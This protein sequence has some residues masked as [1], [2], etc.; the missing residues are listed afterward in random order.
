MLQKHENYP[1]KELNT[2]HFDV[3]AKELIVTDSVN[4]I[5]EWIIQEKPSAENI[6]VLGG[7]SN[8]LFASDYT[9]TLI[10]P[11]FDQ[12][13][14]IYEDNDTVL[15]ETGA[16]KKWDDFVEFCVNNSYYGVENLSLIPGTVGAA[17]VQNIGAYGCE[18][19]DVIEKVNGI[20]LDS[21][22]LL[23][24]Y[25]SE[26][27]FG[28]RNS[29][30]KNELKNRTLVTSVVFRLSKKETYNLSYGRL[31]EKTKELGKINLQNIRKAVIDI[32]GSKLPDP[33]ITGNA[34]SFF[35][36]PEIST[37]LFD[38]LREDYPDIPGYPLDKGKMKIPAGWLIDKAGWKGKAMG[39]AAVHNDQALVLINRGDA[40]GTDI[41]KLASAIEK[42]IKNKFGIGLEKEVIVIR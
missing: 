7:G 34:G 17:P 21:A 12:I 32:R 19:K 24:L 27:R 11:L 9:G 15:I 31:E 16:G 2:F 29:I 3:S 4:D 10:H 30:F 26:C 37:E 20:F 6:L 41:L 5:R 36:N 40:S 18:A 42:D 22:G 8:L 14:I 33:D 13:K 23:T 28:Y 1:L 39:K 25:N 35:K 38:R